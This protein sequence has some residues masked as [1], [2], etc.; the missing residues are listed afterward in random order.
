MILEN[1]QQLIAQACDYGIDEYGNYT[2]AN[3]KEYIQKE[4]GTF[5][6]VNGWN[7]CQWCN[8][9]STCNIT[10]KPASCWKFCCPA[11]AKRIVGCERLE[12]AWGILQ[13]EALKAQYHAG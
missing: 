10:N 8:K 2:C 7:C 3:C 13:I 9:K 6:P 5:H 12:T 1:A 4:N 11:L